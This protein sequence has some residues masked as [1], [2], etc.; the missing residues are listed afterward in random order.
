MTALGDDM[1]GIAANLQDAINYAQ[2]CKIA[3]FD[4]QLQD[5]ITGTTIGAALAQSGATVLFMTANP[6]LLGEGVPGTLGVI[7]KPIFDLEL[8]A[9]IQIAAD[10]RSGADVFA[11]E[12]FNRL[13]S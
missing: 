12:R 8:V 1:M 3:L 5:G 4:A 7:S 11:P 9:V 2:D 13:A 10:F 6:D